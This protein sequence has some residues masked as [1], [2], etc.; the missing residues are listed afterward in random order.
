MSYDIRKFMKG[1]GGG[2]AMAQGGNGNAAVRFAKR[3]RYGQDTWKMRLPSHFRYCLRL[4]TY[5]QA[6]TNLAAAGGV[7]LLPTADTPATPGYN[8]RPEGEEPLEYRNL[9]DRVTTGPNG[10]MSLNASGVSWFWGE[11]LPD[12]NCPWLETYFAFKID[13]IG[14]NICDPKQFAENCQRFQYVKQGPACLTFVWPDPPIGDAGPVRRQ[15]PL[16]TSQQ[17][18]GGGQPEGFGSAYLQA[19][20][21]ERGIGAW[22]MIIIP[23]RK[24]KSVNLAAVVNQAGWDSLIDMGFKPRQTM[25]VTK[26]YCSNGGVD[27]EDLIN[28]TQA[29]QSKS[30]AANNIGS[31][32]SDLTWAKMKYVDTE[33]VCQFTDVTDPGTGIIPTNYG[34]IQQTNRQGYPAIPLGSA[35]CFR[36]RQFAPVQQEYNAE[37]EVTATLQTC[38]RQTIPCDLFIDSVTTFKAPVKGTFDL[39]L[40]WSN[41]NSQAAP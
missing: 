26:V 30:R 7:P 31:N 32:L 35:I 38:T 3:N 17:M 4:L 23:P 13:M 34:S 2:R 37:G 15:Y 40:P 5:T 18:A 1:A 27:P 36:F 19:N 16:A 28:I 29:V 10:T 21:E 22:E 12:I 33:E 20:I 9:G 41:P 14:F 25:K 39:D 11:K 6:Q 8:L 24:M